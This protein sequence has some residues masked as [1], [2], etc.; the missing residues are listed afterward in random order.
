[1]FKGLIFGKSAKKKA[2][3]VQ[4]AIKAAQSTASK[5]PPVSVAWSK[6]EKGNDTAV[7]DGWRVTIFKSDG[8]WNYCISEIF[9][10]EDIADGMEDDPQFGDGYPSKAA[11]KKA[12]LEEL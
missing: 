10:A 12:A 8:E 2:S 4:K 1:M 9:D 6:S 11:A 7:V 3:L 5:T